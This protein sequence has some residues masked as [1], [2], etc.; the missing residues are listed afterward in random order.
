MMKGVWGVWRGG[1]QREGGAQQGG[2]SAG[3][4]GHSAVTCLR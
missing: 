2:V 4:V 3:V 1:A